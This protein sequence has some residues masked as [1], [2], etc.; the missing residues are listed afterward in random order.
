MPTLQ[1]LQAGM[2]QKRLAKK[3]PA[4]TNSPTLPTQAIPMP[5]T[6]PT[7]APVMG[8]V[9]K[10][11][12]ATPETPTT[13]TEKPISQFNEATQGQD[14]QFRQTYRQSMEAPK[15]ETQTTTTPTPTSPTGLSGAELQAYNQLT[16]VEQET[17]QKL[18]TQGVKAQTD[19]LAKAKAN[20]EFNMSQQEKN[21]KIQENENAIYEIQ[22]AEQLAQAKKSL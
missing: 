16:P 15:V 20:V 1:E 6:T 14:V 9:P 13:P 3:A 4:S 19:Y 2:E 7:T 8:I 18:A 21:L 12:V 5:S 10:A 11:P 17:Y 22:S